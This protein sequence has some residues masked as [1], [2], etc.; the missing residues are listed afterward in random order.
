MVVA[1]VDDL[2]FASKLRTA[3][4][5]LDV[6]LVFA[7]T[8]DDILAAVRE[9][10]PQLLILDLNGTRMAPLETLRAVKGDA[11]LSQVPVVGYVSHVD[12]DLVAAAHAAGADRVMARSQFVAQ[13][14]DL[15]AG[16][17]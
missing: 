16:A 1:A 4:R 10:A 17:R 13:L 11:A 12:V 5:Q 7:R 8:P 6:A 3:A 9:H 15:L 2:L 14:P